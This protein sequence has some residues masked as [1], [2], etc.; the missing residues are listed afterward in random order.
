MPRLT[1]TNYFFY[2]S[3]LHDLWNAD[4]SRFGYLTSRDQGHLHDFFRFTEPLTEA[5]RQE[6]RR[7]IT[8]RHP[9][10]PA[11]AGRALRHLAKTP[12]QAE[13][14]AAVAARL[15]VKRTLG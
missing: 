3:Y 14:Q 1:S 11:C 4:P 5:E 7:Q 10:L 12:S 2:V 9:S 8:Q 15:K 13:R 6:H